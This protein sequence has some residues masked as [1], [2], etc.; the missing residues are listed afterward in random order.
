[1]KNFLLLFISIIAIHSS[2]QIAKPSSGT[3]QR[4]EKFFSNYVE[5]RNVDV[6]LPEN[7]DATKKYAVLYMHDGQM[8][9][10]SSIT[11]NKQEW[12][13]DEVMSQLISSKKIKACIVVG[14]W[15][16][17]EYRHAEYF[18][19]KALAYL[20]DT[21]KATVVKQNLKNN[22]QADNYLKFIVQELKPFIDSAFSTRTN[23]ANTFIAGSSMGGLIS[24]YA[25]C[26][27]PKV[28]GGAACLSTHWIGAIQQKNDYIPTA[29]AEYM[30]NNLPN[31]KNHTIYYDYGTIEL[32]S[33]YKRHQLKVDA[34][35]LKKGYK[36][37]R[38]IT[39][40]F[41]GKNHSEKAWAQRFEIP[42]SFL[43]NK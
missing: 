35:M 32:D 42:I 31:P 20:P 41:I 23:Q 34:I 22:A 24:M 25:I 17:G 10:D 21:I 27:Y 2:A 15:N 8:L 11:W 28:F 1:M 38:W 43:L 16:N 14:I 26:E 4:F 33:L 40:E 5:P 12:Q 37:K 7:Y 9:F 6:W 19:A 18:P 13:V 39:K 30:V 29:F 3:I 36:S